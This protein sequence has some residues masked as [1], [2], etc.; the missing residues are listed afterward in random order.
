[1]AEIKNMG[2]WDNSSEKALN[3][4]ESYAKRNEQKNTEIL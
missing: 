1:M 2:S 3:A 4:S